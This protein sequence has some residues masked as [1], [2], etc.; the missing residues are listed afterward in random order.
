MAFVQMVKFLTDDEIDSAASELL[1]RYS[2]WCS[3][4][5]AAPIPMDAIIEKFLKITFEVC[6]LQAMLGPGVLGAT[7]FDQKIIR[8]DESLEQQEGRLSF[9]M[10]HEVGHW[11][12]HR[13]QYEADQVTV[14]LF[15][16]EQDEPLPAI[17]CRSSQKKTRPEWQAD[18]FAARLLMPPRLV[19]AAFT[20]L[21]GGEPVLLDDAAGQ[22]TRFGSLGELAALVMSKGNFSNVSNEA[23]RIRLKDL[24]L[25]QHANEV[26]RRLV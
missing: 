24:K 8:V 26:S 18:Q 9:T 6:D 20:A 1:R 22:T 23:M 25:V 16:N 14:P 5:V 12:L 2:K 13:P 11:V 3:L 19:R 4:P 17:V 15:K 10:A 21:A 7:W